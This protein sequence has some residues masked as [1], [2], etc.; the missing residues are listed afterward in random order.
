[1]LSSWLLSF[2]MCICSRVPR[3]SNRASIATHQ[4]CSFSAS[5]RCTWW[6]REISMPGLPFPM[7][8]ETF[9]NEQEFAAM[10]GMLSLPA[11]WLRPTGPSIGAFHMVNWM[12][13]TDRR[14]PSVRKKVFVSRWYLSC[15]NNPRLLPCPTTLRQTAFWL[16]HPFWCLSQYGQFARGRQTNAYLDGQR[17]ERGRWRGRG[18]CCRKKLVW[19]MKSNQCVSMAK[20]QM[21]EQWKPKTEQAVGWVRG[22]VRCGLGVV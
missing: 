15:S 6:W 22:G 14:P 10:P 8:T 2:I 12:C 4:V 9:L 20:I 5:C 7:A 13:D 16:T 1:M 11:C 18:G 3:L 21:V 19:K 17:G